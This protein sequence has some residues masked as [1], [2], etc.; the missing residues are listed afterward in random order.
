MNAFRRFWAALHGV[1]IRPEDEP[2]F[3]GVRGLSEQDAG[4]IA[5]TMLIS[6]WADVEY[7]G[8]G[9]A[10]AEARRRRTLGLDVEPEVEKP[11]RRRLSKAERQQRKLEKLR[12]EVERLEARVKK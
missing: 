11:K 9:A 4:H 12:A 3:M 6:K 7:Y 1:R 8:P 10:E 2:D 5:A